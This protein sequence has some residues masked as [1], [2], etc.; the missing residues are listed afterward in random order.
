M[1]EN[2]RYCGNCGRARML[3]AVFCAFCGRELDDGGVPPELPKAPSALEQAAVAQPAAGFWRRFFAW[4]IDSWVVSIAFALVLAGL[5]GGFDAVEQHE[6]SAG[7]VLIGAVVGWLYSTLL[8]CSSWQGTVGKRLIGIKVTDFAGRRISFGKAGLRTVCKLLS[9]IALC[10]GF[11]MAGFTRRK[12][13][14]HD[15]ITGCLVVRR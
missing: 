10:I 2:V 5:L 7:V 1:T 11:L 8:E 12:Q 15:M 13:A 4:W 6:A 9:A 3:G 14:L